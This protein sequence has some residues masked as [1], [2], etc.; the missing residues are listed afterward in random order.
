MTNSSNQ[1]KHFQDIHRFSCSYVGPKFT[2]HP[3][4]S[5]LLMASLTTKSSV[6]VIYNLYLV[7]YLTS[8]QSTLGD[9]HGGS[10]T[11]LMLTSVFLILNST[12]TLLERNQITTRLLSTKMKQEFSKQL[13]CVSNVFI[14]W[15]I[16]S[17]E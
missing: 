8:Q 9:F 6:K 3:C 14:I 17:I 4:I 16:R 2:L 7:Y 10:L 15:N 1:S 12:Q 5:I 11:I 13:N